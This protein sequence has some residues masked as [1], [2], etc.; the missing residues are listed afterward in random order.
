MKRGLAI[1]IVVAVVVIIVA[2]LSNST[3]LT[4]EV[5]SSPNLQGSDGSVCVDKDGSKPVSKGM[6]AAIYVKSTVD[7]TYQGNVA[8][9]ADACYTDT[10]VI[11]RY[12]R[13][14]NGKAVMGSIKINCPTGY[15]CSD[16]ACV[17][18]S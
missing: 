1:V 12:C 6:N 14:Q 2:L 4:G 18:Q 10:I 15:R 3:T 8:T 7:K 16:G 13:L 11:E 17:Q 5:T 9:E